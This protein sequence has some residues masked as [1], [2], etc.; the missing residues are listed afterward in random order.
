MNF[1]IIYE[2]KKKFLLYYQLLLK[3]ILFI[4]TIII[5]VEW[6]VWMVQSK[7]TS[8]GY[9]V[10]LSSTLWSTSQSGYQVICSDPE[11]DLFFTY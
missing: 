7:A 3:K 6:K 8:G 9:D 4:K 1:S 2:M 10:T 5:F 11:K